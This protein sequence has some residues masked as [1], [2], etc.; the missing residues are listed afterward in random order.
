L[1]VSGWVRNNPDGTV[2]A[3]AEGSRSDLQQLAQRCHLGPHH[4][5]VLSVQAAWLEAT[6]EFHAFTVSR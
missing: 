6:G 2:E 3:V 4:S 5:R 1:G